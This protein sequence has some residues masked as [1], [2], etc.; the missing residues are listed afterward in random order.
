M[1]RIVLVKEQTDRSQID[2]RVKRFSF[3]GKKKKNLTQKVL[4]FSPKKY[5]VAGQDILKN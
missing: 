4:A 3:S 1:C 2:I 5:F